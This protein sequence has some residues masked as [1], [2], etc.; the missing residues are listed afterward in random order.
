VHLG[1]GVLGRDTDRQ[2]WLAGF[3]RAFLLRRYGI[4]RTRAA[5]RALLF[6]AFVVGWGA[7]RLRTLAPAGGRLAGWRAAAGDR[8]SAPPDAIDRSITPREALRRLV[9]DRRPG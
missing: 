2:R 3:A 6:E 1:G 9:A 7:V 4:L 8:L 5:A